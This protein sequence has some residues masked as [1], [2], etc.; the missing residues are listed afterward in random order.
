MKNIKEKVSDP[1]VILLVGL[2]ISIPAFINSFMVSATSYAQLEWW[3]K[4]STFGIPCALTWILLTYLINVFK[5][6]KK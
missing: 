6:K 4:I 1:R 5:R 2:I 3:G